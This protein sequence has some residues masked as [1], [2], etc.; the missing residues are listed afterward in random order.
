MLNEARLRDEQRTLSSSLDEDLQS[1][2]RVSRDLATTLDELE[3]SM[4]QL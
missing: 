2:S 1:Y 4:G 3:Q